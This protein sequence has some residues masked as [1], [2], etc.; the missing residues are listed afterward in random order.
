MEMVSIT[1]QRLTD[2][3]SSIHFRA[4]ERDAVAWRH[5]ECAPHCNSEP[6]HAMPKSANPLVTSGFILSTHYVNSVPPRSEAILKS[7]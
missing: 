1:K 2:F 5:P 4:W 6:H 7:V 3:A